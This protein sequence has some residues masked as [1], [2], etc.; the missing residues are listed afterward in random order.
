SGT[1]FRR[2]VDD[3][4]ETVEGELEAILTTSNA[5][6]VTIAAPLR[7]ENLVQPF[8]LAEDAVVPPGIYRF[9]GVR[10]SFRKPMGTLLQIP[11][12]VQAGRFYDGVQR[13]VS[14]RPSWSVSKHL[15]VGTGYSLDRVDFEERGQS[16]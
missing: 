14:V 2:N 5:Y 12:T 13:S 3:V 8:A 11:V 4:V 1:A 10:L 6:V 15:S 16:F 7:Y 9:A